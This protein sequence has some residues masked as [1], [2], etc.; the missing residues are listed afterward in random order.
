MPSYEEGFPRV[1]LEAMSS[2]VPVI[3]TTAGGSADVVGESYPYL[4]PTGDVDAM[5]RAL[6]ELHDL[7]PESRAEIAQSLRQR[8]VE[9]FATEPV[10]EMLAR[11]LA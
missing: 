2:E 11:L 10:A 1:L 4:V 6:S 3:T 7:T 8:V 9:R 5:V